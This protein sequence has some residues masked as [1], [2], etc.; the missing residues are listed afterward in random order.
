MILELRQ[1][2]AANDTT[3]NTMKTF[4]LAMACFPEVQERAQQEL[5]RV[6]EGQKLPTHA[7]MPLLP[8][9]RA[10]IKEVLR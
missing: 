4:I 1:W 6:L 9:L 8:Y 3:T 7:D 10:L 5:D 2:V